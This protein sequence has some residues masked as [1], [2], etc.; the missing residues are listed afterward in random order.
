MNKWLQSLKKGDPVAVYFK[1]LDESIPRYYGLNLV[2]RVTKNQIVLSG[3]DKYDRHSGIH[4][5]QVDWYPRFSIAR[6]RKKDIER[7]TRD[8]IQEEVRE[9]LW[10]DD[11]IYLNRLSTRTLKTMLKELKEYVATK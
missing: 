11:E 9:H 10:G 4:V 2:H 6:P 8:N 3:G 5:D 1:Y 7:H